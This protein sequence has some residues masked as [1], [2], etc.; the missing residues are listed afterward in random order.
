MRFALIGAAGYIAPRHLQAIK[1]TGNTLVAACDL[2]DSVGILDRFFP[3]AKFFTEIERFD[4]HLEKLKY[5]GEAVDYISICSPN[6]LHDAHC[7][8]ALRL[9]ANAICEKPLTINPWNLEPLQEIEQR[10]NKRVN[11]I[12]QLRYHP[13]VIKLKSKIESSNS[14]F[15]VK[16]DYITRRGSWYHTSWKGNQKKSGG[17]VTNIGVHLFDLVLWLF[18]SVHS[19]RVQSFSEKKASGILELER[20]K[21]NWFLSVDGEDLE[22]GEQARRVFSVG[23]AL[24]NL[25]SG[26]ELLHTTCYQE[27]LDNKGF[28]IVDTIP[29]IELVSKICEMGNL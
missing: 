23:G 26:L 4:R 11:V 25:S 27:I 5:K 12:L 18:G 21:I 7:R 29:A 2:H 19:N 10:F 20:A 1:D 17:L 16:I 28:G 13:E 6:Y 3:E 8:F 22:E 14:K 15:E 24:V 9:G